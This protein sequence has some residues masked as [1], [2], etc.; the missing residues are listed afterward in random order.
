MP[1]PRF[2]YQQIRPEFATAEGLASLFKR[3][4]RLAALRVW[5][6]DSGGDGPVLTALESLPRP[7]MSLELNSSRGPGW[8]KAQLPALRHLKSVSVLDDSRDPGI[9]RAFPTDR[10][11]PTLEHLKVRG[12]VLA[13]G[14]AVPASGLAPPLP[15][16]DRSQQPHW[17]CRA[18]PLNQARPPRRPRAR[19]VM[20][21]GVQLCWEQ[22]RARIAW[23]ALR[24]GSA[25]GSG[26][27]SN[28]RPKQRNVNSCRTVRAP[29][30]RA[31]PAA[32]SSNQNCPERTRRW[33]RRSPQAAS[34]TCAL[35]RCLFGGGTA[36]NL[37]LCCTYPF[38]FSLGPF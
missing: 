12:R 5:F 14:A 34:T 26:C 24:G 25:A 11:P 30:A 32:P 9:F 15:A 28:A 6:G 31:A 20:A 21:E 35:W 13:S 38:D 23:A 7:L 19:Q 18:R 29:R 22:V 3:A 4:P 37:L 8:F 33:P 36:A 1:L 10:L 16:S 2:Q 17:R 27:T